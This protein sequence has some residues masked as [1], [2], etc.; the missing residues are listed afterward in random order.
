MAS[1]GS[2]AASS[3]RGDRHGDA[4]SQRRSTTFFLSLSLLSSFFLLLLSCFLEDGK[5]IVPVNSVK[6]QKVK[7][8]AAPKPIILPSLK[9]ENTDMSNPGGREGEEEEKMRGR[10][11]ETQTKT[12]WKITKGEGKGESKGDD[13]GLGHFFFDICYFSYYHFSLSFFHS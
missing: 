8:V 2:T 4:S 11:G 3:L 10:V 6:T 9:S 12:G 5:Y 1:R 13:G 7:A